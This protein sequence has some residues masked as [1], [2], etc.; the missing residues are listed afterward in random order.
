MN[1]TFTIQVDT[2]HSEQV[3]VRD[4][5]KTGEIAIFLHKRNDPDDRKRALAA[6][7][8]AIIELKEKTL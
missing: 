6:A 3:S 1:I 8:L 5:K 4:T 2:N 7:F